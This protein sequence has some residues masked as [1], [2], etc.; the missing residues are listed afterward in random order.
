MLT[1]KLG[2]AVVS[3]EGK[4]V[5]VVSDWDI[6]RAS[7]DKTLYDTKLRTIMSSNVVTVDPKDHLL[8]SIRKLELNGISAMPVVDGD[9][10]V[11][12]ISSDIFTRHTLLRLLQND[13]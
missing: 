9:R 6:T 4:L 13:M 7:S 11:G 8:D 2:L 5:G 10:A 3:D 1:R 12:V